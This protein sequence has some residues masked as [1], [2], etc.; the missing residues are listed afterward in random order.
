[1]INTYSK[2]YKNTNYIRVEID[3]L[4]PIIPSTGDSIYLDTRL[5]KDQ[6]QTKS[7]YLNTETKYNTV[8][9]PYITTN[10]LIQYSL[11]PIYNIKVI[12]RE[13]SN[14]SKLAEGV[15]IKVYTYDNDIPIIGRIISN[16]P[17]KIDGVEAW[18][19]VISFYE[20]I[21]D[22]DS[23]ASPLIY[24]NCLKKDFDFTSLN[25]LTFYNKLYTP[26]IEREEGNVI[27]A[28]NSAFT[29]DLIGQ[30]FFAKT[31]DGYCT[32]FVAD[33]NES[34]IGLS[35]NP[36]T[37]ST[38]DLH[39]YIPINIYTQLNPK[40]DIAEP[41]YKEDEGKTGIKF[42]S[43]NLK[44]RTL[45]CKFFLTRPEMDLVKLYLDNS[46]YKQNNEPKGIVFTLSSLANSNWFP[47]LPTPL[48]TTFTAQEFIK[49]EIKTDDKYINQYEFNLIMKYEII[50]NFNY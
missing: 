16:V 9:E 27:I 32:V 23:I 45:N 2:D 47:E 14:L 43:S 10:R 20:C 13:N 8:Y 19:T 40:F 18:N 24:P 38:I 12:I 11:Y 6:A 1:M 39:V 36:A 50:E 37:I 28:Y 26:V 33:I 44:Y 35:I 3:G 5:Y 46:F 17:T 42:L 25:K 34:T 7:V 29:N 31:E 49:P 30:T 41:D 48:Q 4:S 21:P 15:P 22:Y